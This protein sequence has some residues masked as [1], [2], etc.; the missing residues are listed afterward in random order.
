MGV[1]SCPASKRGKGT[2]AARTITSAA[3]DARR[4]GWAR[5]WRGP[6]A[7]SAGS[8]R[9]PVRALRAVRL[10]VSLAELSG[11]G[12]GRVQLPLH[13]CW[14]GQVVFDL[15]DERER[16]AAYAVALPHPRPAVPRHP[17]SP[18]PHPHAGHLPGDRRRAAVLP[19]R[20]RNLRG[21]DTA[22]S[23]AVADSP[24]QSPVQVCLAPPGDRCQDRLSAAS[25]SC[26][27]TCP[28]A[29]AVREQGLDGCVTSPGT[30][31]RWPRNV[32]RTRTGRVR[33]R[34]CGP[35]SAAAAAGV[36]GPEVEEVARGRRRHRD[37]AVGGGQA[38]GA[39]KVLGHPVG[40]G[41]DSAE[42]ALEARA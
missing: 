32:S 31:G 7:G 37:A 24:E 11:P 30:K 16:A 21:G 33:G 9:G 35:G 8:P 10:P 18:R 15:D 23:R 27:A 12:S 14:S 34:A 40:V 3:V 6:A 22:G 38:A 41:L 29:V 28:F 2:E 19:A 39:A 17:Q 26:G 20:R 42:I 5:P 13:P 1:R 36:R 25:R 4:A